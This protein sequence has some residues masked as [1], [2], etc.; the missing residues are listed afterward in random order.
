MADKYVAILDSTG[1]FTSAFV[2]KQKRKFMAVKQSLVDEPINDGAPQGMDH[3]WLLA[4]QETPLF[5]DMKEMPKAYSLGRESDS[6]TA[7]IGPKDANH[8]W[9]RLVR[10][11]DSWLLDESLGYSVD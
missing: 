6:N 3:N 1:F 7:F 9:F 11:N 8:I 2:A 4:V 5:W 10:V